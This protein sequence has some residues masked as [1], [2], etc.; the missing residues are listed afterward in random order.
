V[1]GKAG[2]LARV[3]SAL[4]YPYRLS[5]LLQLLI[6]PLIVHDWDGFVFVRSVKDLLMSGA[7]PYAVVE[8]DPTYIHLGSAWPPVNTW[9]AYPP[10]PLLL[11]L[12]SMA[13]AVGAGAAPWIVRLA[14]KLPF[15]AGTLVLAWVGARLLRSWGKASE[16]ATWERM[17]LLNPLLIFVSAGWGMFDAWMVALLLVSVLLIDRGRYRL[18]G[19]A[20]GASALIKLFPLFA[21]PAFLFY[22]AR[23]AHRPQRGAASFTFAAAATFALVSLPF[24]LPHPRGFLLQ[25]LLKHVERPPQGLSLPAVVVECARLAASFGWYDVTASVGTVGALCFGVTL[26]VTVATTVVAARARTSAAFVRAMLGLFLGV[27]YTSKVLNEQYFVIPAALYAL[28]ACASGVRWAQ[29]GYRA[30]TFGGLAASLIIGWHL[31]TFWPA[32]IVLPL[33]GKKPDVLIG[34]L[35]SAS[36][37]SPASFT[38]LPTLL[39]VVALSPALVIAVRRI[40]HEVRAGARIISAVIAARLKRR[41]PGTRAVATLLLLLPP[42]VQGTAMAFERHPVVRPLQSDGRRVGAFYYLWWNNTSHDPA[43]ADGNWRDGVSEVPADGYYSISSAKLRKDFRLARAN[44]VDFIVTSFHDYDVPVM[45]AALHAA[46]EADVAVAPLIELEE[47]YGHAEHRSPDDG[48]TL[49]ESTSDAIV[50]MTSKALALF[51]KA[52]SAYRPHGKLA[53]FVYDSYFSGGSWRAPFTQ[54]L[55]DRA[56]SIAAADA[57]ASQSTPPSRSELARAAPGSTHDMLV[58]TSHGDVWRRA[59]ADLFRDFWRGV[60]AE[61]ERRFGPLFVVSGE[62]WNPGQPFHRGAQTALDG[63]RVFDASFIYSPSFVWV[64]HKQDSYERN[65][66]RWVVRNVLQAQYARGAGH[67]FVATVM[68]VYDDRVARKKG[69][70]IPAT[71]PRGDTYDL[72]WKLAADA[73]PDLVLISTWNEFFEG[74]AIE[75]TVEHGDAFVTSTRAWAERARAAGVRKTKRGLVLT[76]EASAH[77]APGVTDPSA[78]EHYA[79]NLQVMAERDLGDYSFDAID[80]ESPVLRDKDLAVYELV[81]AEP[82]PRAR[83]SAIAALVPRLEAWVNAGGRL[84][85]S[86]VPAGSAWEPLVRAHAQVGEGGSTLAVTIDG[87]A[88]AIPAA[89]R[90]QIEDLDAASTITLRFADGQAAGH[91]AAWSLRSGSGTI[92]AAA[93]N[94]SGRDLYPGHDATTLLCASIRPALAPTDRCENTRPDVIP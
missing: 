51:A 21:A 56:L 84:F 32:D 30:T 13:I 7:T 76:S 49:D 43:R 12:P 86:G 55:L 73:A 41:M 61:L 4:R 2:G 87:V 46:Y 38:F 64:V 42:I 82:S 6:A 14:L 80:V 67:P 18:A 59:Y 54:H 3:A 22:V 78:D 33:Y 83:V 62:T 74:S 24:A 36:G 28:V 71:G 75:P 23:R 72:T 94:V 68:P 70:T 17:I 44:G 15:I 1:I 69:F 47:V 89:S 77:Y 25:V 31:F 11:M 92:A 79:R 53:L 93:V 85:V 16:A 40:I 63:M 50:E 60:R 65:W 10:L 90:P 9:Y 8:A 5:L 29:A 27:L 20:F 58:D 48:F 45:E 26:G 88:L 19:V 66:Q 57:Q 35:A 81:L 39:A 91:P 52:P 34:R 37:L